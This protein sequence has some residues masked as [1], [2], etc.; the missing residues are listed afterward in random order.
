VVYDKKL[1][2]PFNVAYITF[3]AQADT[4]GGAALL[5]SASITDADGSTTVCQ[6]MATAGGSA[7]FGGPWM[8]LLKL[9]TDADNPADVNNCNDGAGGSA[10]CHDNSIIFSCCALLKPSNTPRDVQIRLASSNGSAVFYQDST[11][12]I[13][14]LAGRGYCQ[15]VGTAPH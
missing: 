8:T 14:A 6:P 9:P 12:N 10:D 11:V 13:D 3:S 15:Q 7:E 1:S 4:H 2:I 5:M